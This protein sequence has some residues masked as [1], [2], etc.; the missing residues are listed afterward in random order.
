[1]A[2]GDPVAEAQ[3]VLNRDEHSCYGGVKYDDLRAICPKCSAK[4]ASGCGMV[5][6]YISELQAHL[7]AMIALN[8]SLLEPLGVDGREHVK[9]LGLAADALE[10]EDCKHPASYCAEATAYIERQAAAL[11]AER[12]RVRKLEA[13]AAFREAMMDDQQ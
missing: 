10:F 1:M 2:N 5:G 13:A 11:S 4:P 12:D 7:S 3:K 9:K 6:V 8:R